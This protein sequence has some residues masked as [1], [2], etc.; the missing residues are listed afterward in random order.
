MYHRNRLIKPYERVGYQLKVSDRHVYIVR[1]FNATS[2]CKN[3]R[4]GQ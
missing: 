2:L 1:N 4:Q 3:G